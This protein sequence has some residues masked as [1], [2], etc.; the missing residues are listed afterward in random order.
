MDNER[1]KQVQVM[2]ES[3]DKIT[4]GIRA[5]R[6]H[7]D[8]V[9]GNQLTSFCVTIS[10]AGGLRVCQSQTLI[11]TRHQETSLYTAPVFLGRTKTTIYSAYSTQIHTRNQHKHTDHVT[12][13]G[14]HY[15]GCFCVFVPCTNFSNLLLQVTRNYSCQIPDF[16]HVADNHSLKKIK[17]NQQYFLGSYPVSYTH[18]TLPT[19]AVV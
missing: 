18:L 12:G 6:R 13:K 15:P 11:L 8:E 9:S 4:Q 19:M 10:N 7:F 16:L 2:G 3:P 1:R 17:K 14:G 5:C